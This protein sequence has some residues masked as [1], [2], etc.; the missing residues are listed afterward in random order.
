VGAL[1]LHAFSRYDFRPSG[2]CLVVQADDLVALDW[3]GS[4]LPAGAKFA[5][6]STN[7]WVTSPESSELAAPADAGAWVEPLA[8][9]SAITIPNTSD[10]ADPQLLSA[11]CGARVRFLYV[12]GTPRSFPAAEL[13][14]MHDWY[15]A[16][17][18]LSGASI[19]EVTACES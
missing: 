18:Q 3:I 9:F 13:V 1:V 5:I 17:L 11:L 16:R 6:A 15:R 8:G 10:F 14:E 12:G 4:R 19:F 2:C 7:L